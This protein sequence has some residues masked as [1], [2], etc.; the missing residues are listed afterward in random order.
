MIFRIAARVNHLY[1][2]YNATV[3]LSRIGCCMVISNGC[4]EGCFACLELPI[5]NLSSLSDPKLR[6]SIRDDHRILYLLSKVTPLVRSIILVK[7]PHKYNNSILS[8]FQP[9]SNRYAISIICIF[10]IPRR[11]NFLCGKL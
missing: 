6:C 3:A 9:D 5:R 2:G 4:F 7:F 11:T 8:S 1:I 10:N